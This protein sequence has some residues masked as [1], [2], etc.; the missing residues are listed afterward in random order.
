NLT[1]QLAKADEAS[2]T[3]DYSSQ[4][5][6]QKAIEVTQNRQRIADEL[7]DL[8]EQLLELMLEIEDL[9]AQLGLQ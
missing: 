8:E 4:S 6:Q 7:A 1:E 5:G 2:L 3:L 9:E